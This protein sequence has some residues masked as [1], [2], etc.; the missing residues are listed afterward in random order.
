M[1]R[2]QPTQIELPERTEIK[3]IEGSVVEELKKKEKKE[4]DKDK[5][6]LMSALKTIDS[7]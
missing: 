7:L 4:E 1:Q 6:D 3:K 2:E 5:D